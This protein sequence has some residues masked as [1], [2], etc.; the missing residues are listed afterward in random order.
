MVGALWL[1][2]LADALRPGYS[3]GVGPHPSCRYEAS[4]AELAFQLAALMAFAH[5]LALSDAKRRKLLG[6]R[7]VKRG[8]ATLDVVN[9]QDYPLCTLFSLADVLQEFG[10]PV[11]VVRG[12]ALRYWV[13][14][15]GSKPWTP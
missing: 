10:R 5:D 9:R 6:M 4:M 12:D 13:P 1:A 14:V 8:G 15:A 3:A 2:G 11:Q 7:Q